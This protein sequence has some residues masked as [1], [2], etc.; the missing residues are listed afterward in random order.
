VL[1]A[2]IL[3]TACFAIVGTCVPRWPSPISAFVTGVVGIGG[4]IML[5]R[6][7]AEMA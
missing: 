5:G 3:L 4:G 6:V 1:L 7:L 2:T